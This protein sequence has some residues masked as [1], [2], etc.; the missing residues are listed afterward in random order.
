MTREITSNADLTVINLEAPPANQEDAAPATVFRLPTGNLFWLAPMLW[1]A[2]TVWIAYFYVVYQI[3][4]IPAI[5]ETG[6]TSTRRIPAVGLAFVVIVGI[7][8]ILMLVTS[9]ISNP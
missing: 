8:L 2:M 5:G 3:F 7:I 1:I 6:D 4:R 9:P